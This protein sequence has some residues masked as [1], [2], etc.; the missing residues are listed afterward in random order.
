MRNE[1]LMQAATNMRIFRN[2]TRNKRSKKRELETKEQEAERKERQRIQSAEQRVKQ[3]PEQKA[4]INARKREVQKIRNKYISMARQILAE[5]NGN[6]QILRARAKIKVKKAENLLEEAALRRA[7]IDSATGP[8]KGAWEGSS[9]TDMDAA[10]DTA[11]QKAEDAY[12][13]LI[14][15]GEE[16][17]V[18][19][20]LQDRISPIASHPIL[21]QNDPMEDVETS[22]DGQSFIR[23]SS[24]IQKPPFERVMEAIDPHFELP[25]YT[26]EQDARAGGK[27]SRVVV[28]PAQYRAVGMGTDVDSQLPKG[29]KL[30]RQTY[31][32]AFFKAGHL[33]NADL[34]GDGKDADNLTILTARA[35]RQMTAFDNNVKYALAALYNLYRESHKQDDVSFWKYGIE[36]EIKVSDNKWGKTSPDRFIA[37]AISCKATPYG[38]APDLTAGTWAD[39]LH[40]TFLKYI[41]LANENGTIRNELLLDTQQS[42]ESLSDSMETDVDL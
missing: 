41:R 23:R 8:E 38:Q 20:L 3:T 12:R 11:I 2:E 32:Q 33:L 14:E 37:Q 21:G 4:A 30:A 13:Q 19:A 28:S 6:Q 9:L 39:T 17:E 34:G 16:I 26:P 36:I 24:R 31:P 29:I 18:P 22:M 27:V 35:N 40:Q 7:H 25:A 1:T 42:E 5:A 15:L 10:A